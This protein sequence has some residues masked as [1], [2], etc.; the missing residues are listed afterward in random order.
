MACN[1]TFDMQ[2]FFSAVQF[3][4]Y[5]LNNPLVSVEIEVQLGVVLL[6]D[7]PGGLFDCLGANATH[8][9]VFFRRW[10]RRVNPKDKQLS[11]KRKIAMNSSQKMAT[12]IIPA[13]KY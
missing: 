1:V 2:E 13:L 11:R 7:D 5:L 8:F 3:V 6:D 9:R 12:I 4:S 10:A